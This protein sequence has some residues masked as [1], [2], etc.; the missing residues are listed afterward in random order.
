M[1]VDQPSPATQDTQSVGECFLNQL[2]G[3]ANGEWP[4]ITPSGGAHLVLGV[5]SYGMR[6]LRIGNIL[7]YRP[8][9]YQFWGWAAREWP[10]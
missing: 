5:S 2:W 10:I 6:Q 1:D 4:S 8:K 7:H 9:C 3:V